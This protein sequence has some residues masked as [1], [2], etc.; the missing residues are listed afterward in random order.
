MLYLIVNDIDFQNA[1]IKIEHF[2][3]IKKQKMILTNFVKI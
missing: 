2:I 3:N 1:G